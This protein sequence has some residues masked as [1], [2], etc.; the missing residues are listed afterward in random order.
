MEGSGAVWTDAAGNVSEIP[1]A[2]IK[3]NSE[4]ELEITLTPGATRGPAALTIKSP[5][6]LS[7]TSDVTVE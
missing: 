3:K 5:G 6:N 4:T 7:T 2:N 1:A